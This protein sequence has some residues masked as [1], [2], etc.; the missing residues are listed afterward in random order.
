MLQT[1]IAFIELLS[2]GFATIGVG[3]TLTAIAGQVFG[4]TPNSER[5]VAELRISIVQ[6]VEY[7]EQSAPWAALF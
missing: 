1:T 6:P 2:L 4:I 5:P 3:A 7:W